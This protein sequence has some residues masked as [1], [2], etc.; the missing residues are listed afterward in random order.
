MINKTLI[1]LTLMLFSCTS[2]INHPNIKTVKNFD[3][4]QY[5]GTWYEVARLDNNRFQKGCNNTVAQ[6]DK[7]DKKISVV[8][9]CVLDNG[10]S[11]EA[12]GV[13]YPVDLYKGQLK[14][15]FFRPFYG[16]YNVLEVS[17]DY[18]YAMV[19]GKD[20]KSLWILSKKQTIESKVLKLF[21]LKAKMMGFD[22]DALRY[23]DVYNQKVIRNISFAF[24]TNK[25][26][27]EN[28]DNDSFLFI[29]L[30]SSAE[31]EEGHISGSINIPAEQLNCNIM[32]HHAQP[33]I[34]FYSKVSDES[35]DVAYKYLSKCSVDKKIYTLR[36]GFDGWKNARFPIIY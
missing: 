2:R 32:K 3:L 36:D 6:Y 12:K 15:S 23:E 25:E 17:D 11:K 30:R 28:Y 27:F 20:L 10:N 34:L 21:L 16:R 4:D 18:N 29:D 33:N 5:M 31:Y 26:A 13:A 19:S 22:V 14:V 8:N 1:A 24:L 7:V 35:F 9:F